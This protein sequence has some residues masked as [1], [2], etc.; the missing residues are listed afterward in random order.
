MPDYTYA[1][2]MADV[3]A[4]KVW[5]SGVGVAAKPWIT[6]SGRE[7]PPSRGGEFLMHALEAG[8]IEFESARVVLRSRRSPP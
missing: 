5:A 2:F 8:F 4:G 1:E 7:H 6:V 3:E